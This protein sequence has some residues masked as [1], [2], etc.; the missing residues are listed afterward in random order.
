M[1]AEQFL[2]VPYSF[3]E[4]KD[5]NDGDRLFLALFVSLHNKNGCTI[6][7]GYLGKMFNL[8]PNTCSE[9][10]TKLKQLGY[11]QVLYNKTTK[12]NTER[13]IIPFL[14]VVGKPKEV[15]GK[16]EWGSR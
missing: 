12:N 16:A 8:N 11:I 5:I 14:K 13:T 4:Y 10:I 15:V 2:K 6:S 9:R 3:F 1:S 7:N